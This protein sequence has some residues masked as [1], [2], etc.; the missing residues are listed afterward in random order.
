[1]QDEVVFL[2]FGIDGAKFWTRCS[3]LVRDHGCDN[4]L[5]YMEVLLDTFGMDRPKN[6]AETLDENLLF[7]IHRSF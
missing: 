2:A 4:E 7:Q 5:A 6:S 3:E 1:M